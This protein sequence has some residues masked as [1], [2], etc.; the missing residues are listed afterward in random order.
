MRGKC[1]SGKV[2]FQPARA[3]DKSV[4][5]NPGG[6]ARERRKYAWPQNSRVRPHA[7]SLI[8]NVII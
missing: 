4:G 3:V 8:L 7:K 5:K 2:N 1:L 6:I